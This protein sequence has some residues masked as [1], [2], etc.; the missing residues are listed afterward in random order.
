METDE[1][2]VSWR[3]SIVKWK[4]YLAS[5]RLW[6]RD[7]KTTFVIIF[8]ISPLSMTAQMGGKELSWE[9]TYRPN[10]LFSFCFLYLWNNIIKMLHSI[11]YIVES[12]TCRFLPFHIFFNLHTFIDFLQ[13]ITWYVVSSLVSFIVFFSAPERC[14]MLSYQR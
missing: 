13:Y 10:C 12:W 4:K 11:S 2:C 3:R 8:W 6:A 7:S 9:A 14:C 1:R 5:S